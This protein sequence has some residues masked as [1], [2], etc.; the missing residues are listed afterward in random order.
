MSAYFSQIDPKVFA[1]TGFVSQFPEL[2]LVEL[3]FVFGVF[4]LCYA[5]ASD[6]ID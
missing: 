6:S 4:Y 5:D 2:R 1:P 3:A